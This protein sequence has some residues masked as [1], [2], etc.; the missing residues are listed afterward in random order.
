MITFCHRKID[1]N[2]T[3]EVLSFASFGANVAEPCVLLGL[4]GNQINLEKAHLKEKL[5][6]IRISWG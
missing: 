3:T 1:P 5:Y 4:Q 2:S 6:S